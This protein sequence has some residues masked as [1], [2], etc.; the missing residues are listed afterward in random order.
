L[1]LEAAHKKGYIYRDL[2]PENIILLRRSP[3]RIKLIDF[4]FAR[5]VSTEE[6]LSAGPSASSV[7]SAG[8]P[9]PLLRADTMLGTPEY[10]HRS[11]L[12][13]HEVRSRGKRVTEEMKYGPE[14]DFWTLGV[15][16]CEMLTGGL[17]P[18]A[19]RIPDF[20]S[21][22]PDEKLRRIHEEIESNPEITFDSSFPS[23]ATDII[24]R[25]VTIDPLKRIGTWEGVRRHPFFAGVD[26]AALASATV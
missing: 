17:T 12:R 19:A 1:A 22:D 14:V 8:G 9:P 26:F 20:E 7:S 25:L 16:I 5:K 13:I 11:I 15:F 3:I 2:K 21:L 10:L 4:G 6:V 18:F 24:Q 23:D